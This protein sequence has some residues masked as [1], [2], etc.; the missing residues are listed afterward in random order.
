VSL[1]LWFDFKFLSKIVNRLAI[2]FGHD[3]LLSETF[4]RNLIDLSKSVSLPWDT[5]FSQL[6]VA[7]A[8][9]KK[10]KEQR[11]QKKKNWTP[12]DIE[13]AR[14]MLQ[15]NGDLLPNV[16][17]RGMKRRRGSPPVSEPTQYSGP[18]STARDRSPSGGA[19]VLKLDEPFDSSIC[20]P[21]I[22]RRASTTAEDE[23]SDMMDLEDEGSLSDEDS[24]SADADPIYDQD[25]YFDGADPI[26]DQ[27]EFGSNKR[28]E[29]FLGSSTHRNVYEYQQ[30]ENLSDGSRSPCSEQGS[31][32]EGLNNNDFDAS[33]S[34]RSAIPNLQQKDNKNGPRPDSVFDPS[35]HTH[36]TRPPER[37]LSVIT[38]Q[39]PPKQSSIKQSLAPSATPLPQQRFHDNPIPK[40][41]A[42]GIP[43]MALAQSNSHRASPLATTGDV[44]SRTNSRCV[45]TA[46]QLPASQDVSSKTH[47]STSRRFDT[48]FAEEAPANRPTIVDLTISSE[49]EQIPE[50]TPSLSKS[51]PTGSHSWHPSYDSFRG[52]NWV[53]SFALDDLLPFFAT[54]KSIHLFHSDYL[55]LSSDDPI[56]VLSNK[57]PPRGL[58]TATTI[59]VFPISYNSHWNL[60]WADAESSIVFLYDPL[61][62]YEVRKLAFRAITHVLLSLHPALTW[63]IVDVQGPQQRDAYNCGVFVAVFA[64]HLLA[65]RGPPKSIIPAIWRQVFASALGISDPY[66][67]VV[68]LP[69]PEELVISKD[70]YVQSDT[71]TAKKIMSEQEDLAQ[72]RK[73][74]G[75]SL[76][77]TV[78]PF[79]QTAAI[80]DFLHP[81]YE[82]WSADEQSLEKDR[83]NLAAA[84]TH[85]EAGLVL[86]SSPDLVTAVGARKKEFNHLADEARF[87]TRKKTALS[88]AL[89]TNALLKLH[90]REIVASYEAGISAMAL[91][92]A[93]LVTTLSACIE[94]RSAAMASEWSAK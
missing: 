44:D 91:R 58:D 32:G 39:L 57:L 18:G 15:Q 48:P 56:A 47:L 54:S 74:W 38:E 66:P 8:E 25:E 21:E 17:S 1:S 35:T 73:A 37:V 20:E 65:G 83:A 45:Q 5:A 9:R 43:S 59:Y 36:T 13:D 77:Q 42:T 19:K 55:Q 64:V 49:P 60:A 78:E 41:D 7:R 29:G 23:V 24:E 84:I 12:K 28:R 26:E 71:E 82:R 53:S 34:A 81:V 50:G 86:C 92:Y 67:K 62:K 3:T 94:R 88:E 69:M 27:D 80:Q 4:L 2:E 85:F 70:E 75:S 6:K 63:N 61:S 11:V 79:E 52:T 51:Y 22:G 14:K 46:A 87:V 31:Q 90:L 40:L 76:E 93:E 10:S 33:Q 30:Q 16:T 68:G 89:R 72:L